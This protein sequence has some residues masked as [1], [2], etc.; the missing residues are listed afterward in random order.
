MRTE[1]AEL[2]QLLDALRPR[3]WV[4]SKAGRDQ[5]HGRVLLRARNRPRLRLRKDPL[6]QLGHAAIVG[7]PEWLFQP[8][9]PQ[10][11]QRIGHIERCLEI[12][13][14]ARI[15][16]HPPTLIGIDQQRH[17]RADGLPYG[18]GNGQIFSHGGRVETQL[19]CWK[20]QAAQPTGGGGPFL[21]WAALA[22]GRIEAHPA[23]PSAQQL[24]ERLAANL[25]HEIPERN[26]QRP[27][28]TVHKLQIIEQLHMALNG[29]G[30][31]AEKERFMAGK[32][33]HGIA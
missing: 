19:E 25:A 28:A 14:R 32:T 2:E 11:G 8:V 12:P 15:P 13:G 4:G 29:K 21:R 10:F 5:L 9:D 30:V 17:V 6:A 1:I 27:A 16:R 33:Q 18:A 31:L 24:P 7:A 3:R 23:R 20:A 26:L 22:H